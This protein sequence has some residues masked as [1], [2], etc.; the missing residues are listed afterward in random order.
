[1]K[2]TVARPSPMVLAMTKSGFYGVGVVEKCACNMQIAAKSQGGKTEMDRLS[3]SISGGVATP[4]VRK[5][6]LKQRKRL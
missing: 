4:I 1:M 2:L 3:S 6:T 5:L